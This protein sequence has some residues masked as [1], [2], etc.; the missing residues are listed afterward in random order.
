MLNANAQLG[1]GGKGLA[2][3]QVALGDGKLAVEGRQLTLALRLHDGR[4]KQMG[5]ETALELRQQPERVGHDAALVHLNR[6]AQH[7][8]GVLFG[9]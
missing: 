6:P 2:T 4:V 9:L 1:K 3:R 8:Q 7:G 5:I